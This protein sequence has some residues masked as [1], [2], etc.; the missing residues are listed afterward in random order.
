M[1]LIATDYDGTLNHGGINEEKLD[2]IRRWRAAG[3]LFG[4]ISGRGPDF[5]PTLQ[6]QLGDNFDFLV[7]CNGGIATDSR[8][9]HLFCHQCTNVD[10]KA[11]VADLFGWGAHT[12][13]VN[14]ED[15]CV[16]LGTKDCREPYDYI[17]PE[18]LPPIAAF[19]KMATF[20]ATPE[21]AETM[22]A[23][24]RATYGDK[25][26]PLQNWWCVDIAP[27]GVDKA[28]GIREL[29][30]H[31]GVAEGD[32]IAVGDNL[33]DVAMIE[34]FY[35]YA[36]EHGNEGLKQKATHVTASVTDLILKE[37]EEYYET[38]HLF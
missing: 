6:E 9:N 10:V 3:N 25:V 33:N 24:I 27:Y 20:F 13:Y 1:R 7:S 36:M 4:V 29:C 14:Y 37:L 21:E 11:F 30:A 8:G 34:A 26:N 15:Q 22:A 28:T 17:P 31:Y 38:R 16:L 12:L 2:A 23:K 32:V 5:L 19:T 18:Q 35:S